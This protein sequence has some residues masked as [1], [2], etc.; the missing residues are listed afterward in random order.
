MCDVCVCVRWGIALSGSV[1]HGTVESRHNKVNY[2]GIVLSYDDHKKIDRTLSN[3]VSEAKDNYDSYISTGTHL[4]S[5]LVDT[6][7]HTCTD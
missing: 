4:H 1:K 7:L 6:K 2:L 3:I 5:S